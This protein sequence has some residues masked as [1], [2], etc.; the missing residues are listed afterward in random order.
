MKKIILIDLLIF[1]LGGCKGDNDN[2]STS[3]EFLWTK[4]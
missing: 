4:S 1:L 2:N 3:S